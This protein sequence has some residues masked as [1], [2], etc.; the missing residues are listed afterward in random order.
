MISLSSFS[1]VILLLIEPLFKFTKG[2]NSLL[3]VL[4]FCADYA[5]N[6]MLHAVDPLTAILASVRISVSSLTVLLIVPVIAFITSAV[7]PHIVTKAMHHARL[8]AALEV[9]TISPL[10]ATFAIHL[11]I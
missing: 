7:L 2:P 5:P 9:A 3:L 11:V 6:T 10:E 1:T 4:V 8:E